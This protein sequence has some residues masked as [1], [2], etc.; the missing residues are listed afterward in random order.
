M[1][2]PNTWHR[3][4]VRAHRNLTPT[5]RE[6]E[7]LPE[8]GVTPWR[9]GAHINVAVQI[10]GADATRSYSLVGVPARSQAE[11]VYRIAVKRAQPG[12]G[13]SRFMWNLAV[14]NTLNLSQPANHFELTAN[15]TEHA[16]HYLLIAGG[17]GITPMLGMAQSLAAR[18][19][20]VQ[21][22][23]G[24]RSSAELAYLEELRAALGGGLHVFCDDAG[25]QIKLDEEIAALPHNAQL[26]ICGPLPLLDAARAAWARAGRAA[27]D[28][29]FET[30][31][32]S[33]QFETQAFWVEIPR[34]Q[35]RLEVPAH[36]SLLS[37]LEQAGVQT[38]YEC[39]RGE[40][41]LCAMDVVS[42][43]GTVDHRDVFFSAHEKLS[44]ERLCACVSRV[45][46]AGGG[47]QVVL[48]SAYRADG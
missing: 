10:D 48:D 43:S 11:G 26:W 19:A 38:L 23:Y 40:C 13:G 31:G 28:L 18:G 45:H 37:V 25:Q 46:R 29:R 17:I 6:F 1:K 39:E 7:L 20:K 44:N 30:F 8:R 41:G 5:V 36:R 16:P 34:H 15:L 27:A 33:G 2:H 22:R 42:L 32:N 3:A 12:Q 24:A 47:A 9:V 14:G 21:M 35:L 4:T